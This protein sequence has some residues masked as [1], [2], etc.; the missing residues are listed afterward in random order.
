MAE[1]DQGTRDQ[2]TQGD[3]TLLGGDQ[4]TED[5]NKGAGT[6]DKD[7]DAAGD[8]GEDGA[9]DVKDGDDS[10]S[11]G[12][13]KSKDA[14][15]DKDAEGAPDKYADFIMPD[16]V[17]ANKE[18]LATASTVFKDQNFT[19]AQAQAVVDLQTAEVVKA[20]EAQQSKRADKISGRGDEA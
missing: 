4:G 10:S 1:N 7:Q 13:D 19:Q 20:A 3:A 11:D 12:D 9:K 14:D 6:Q 5:G 2:G 15:G 18:L 17:E 16:G 8:G